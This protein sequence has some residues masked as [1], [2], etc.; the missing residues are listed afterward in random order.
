MRGRGSGLLLA[1]GLLVSGCTTG[2]PADES[3]SLSASG[4][5]SASSA[6]A[7]SGS[8]A[9]DG[10]TSS[11]AATATT[12]QSST[13]DGPCPYLEQDFI[14]LTIG[15][16]IAKVSVTTTMPAYGPL[17]RCDFQRGSGE[18]AAV[19]DTITIE[20]GQGMEQALEAVPG[21]NPVDVGEGGSVR[22]YNGQDRTELAAY[23]GTTL[24]TV[25]LNQESS[26]EA[27]EIAGQVL[28]AI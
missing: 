22:V 13:V 21:G 12:A 5:D 16:R 11:A 1:A 4:Q 3:S 19:V 24:V 18:P 23:E 15:Q 10:S 9:P 6:D 20:A 14:E 25:T 27:V 17:P 7:G 26:L 28:S 2:A 8:A